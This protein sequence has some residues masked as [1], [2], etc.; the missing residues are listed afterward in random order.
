MPMLPVGARQGATAAAALATG[1]LSLVEL[2]AFMEKQREHDA[3]LRREIREELTPAP[4]PPPQELVTAEQLVALQTRLEALQ[5][6]SL[7][8]DE[9]LF[10]IEDLVADYLELKT[11]A[12]AGLITAELVLGDAT[13]RGVDKLRKLVGV[14]EGLIS[15]SAFARQLRRRFV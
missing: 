5:Q 11:T 1:S 10:A 9:E 7:L 8:S 2:S 12:T 13:K 3:Q 15:D 6:G 14:S 4:P